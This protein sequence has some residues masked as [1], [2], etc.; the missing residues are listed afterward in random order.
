MRRTSWSSR[1]PMVEAPARSGPQPANT[2]QTIERLGPQ[3]AAAQTGARSRALRGLARSAARRD[4][5]SQPQRRSG[6]VGA[7][8]TAS[9]EHA[10]GGRC[11]SPWRR[12]TGTN[13]KFR[14]QTKQ[15]P[16]VHRTVDAGY[17]TSAD[18]PVNPL[19]RYRKQLESVE[20]A[21][22]KLKARSRRFANQSAS[23][24]RPIFCSSQRNHAWFASGSPVTHITLSLRSHAH[25]GEK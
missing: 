4:R 12:P 23:E 19:P 8:A 16:S 22:W 13:L 7:P 3:A 24:T 20:T 1:L 6:A 9:Q 11:P 18:A 17:G 14:R 5:R 2:A 25:W 21:K 15:A 10:R